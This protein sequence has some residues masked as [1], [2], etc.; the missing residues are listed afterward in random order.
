MKKLLVI[1]VVVLL[2][3][4]NI[5][6]LIAKNVISSNVSFLENPSASNKNILFD[7]EIKTMMRLAHYRSLSA[8]I[9]KN[10]TIV[11]SKGYGF[12]DK[13]FLQKSSDDTIYM[14]GS[15]S[16][17]ITA[18]ALM[19]LYENGSY[20]FNLDDNVSKWL[21]FD[22]KNPNYP[23]INI[24]FR[25]LLAHQS[26]LHDHNVS[27]PELLSNLPYSYVEK[28]LVP[29]NERYNPAYWADYQ[30]GEKGNYSNLGYILLGY[31]IERMTNMSFE[32]YCQDNIFKP[33]EMYNSSFNLSKLNKLNLAAPY[34]WKDFFIRDRKY[35][36]NFIDPCGGL[37]TTVNDLSHLLVAHL[38]GG[39][40][41]N[42]RILQKSTLDMMH[43]IQYPDSNRLDGIFYYGLGWM[44]WPNQ[45]NE[46][47][48]MGHEG[49]LPGYHT[50]M[51]VRVSDNVSI[52]YFFNNDIYPR[53]LMPKLS[54]KIIGF[55]I[56]Q[57]EDMLF[58]KADEL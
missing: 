21:P 47:T 28:L 4:L 51:H 42:V 53:F 15:I 50:R 33:L 19:Q 46:P 7:L 37:Y 5:P 36:S 52:I 45:N 17:V 49:D 11:W 1:S 40:Y 10:N 32:Q 54:S 56:N 14:A 6:N 35:D 39:V 16:K 58:Q 22:L 13:L 48:M 3:C 29:G 9:I 34:I 24:T 31:I 41:K 26:S 20:N 30:P 12:S 38:N 44:I 27:T 23:N 25:M 55:W 57:I 18:T 43:K 2:V 8:C